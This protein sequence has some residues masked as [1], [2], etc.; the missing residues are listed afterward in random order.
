MYVSFV[1][2]FFLQRHVEGIVTVMFDSPEE[3][4]ICKEALNGRWFAKRQL[5]AETWDGKTKYH[6]EETEE[7]KEAR[8]KKWQKFLESEEDESQ[9]GSKI[10]KEG[11]SSSSSSSTESKTVKESFSSTESKT[12]KDHSQ[13][14]ETV[15][16]D[17]KQKESSPME[18]SS[19]T[20]TA[21]ENS[22]ASS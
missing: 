4:D 10:V 1:Q 2:F 20:Q 15:K 7:E 21:D 6:I 17:S 19:G 18:E 11:P 5:T 9:R 14:E 22:G 12:V 8:L 3:A 16:E 13:K